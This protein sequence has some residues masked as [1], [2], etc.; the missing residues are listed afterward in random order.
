MHSTT[1]ASH[2]HRKRE[3]ER[4]SFFSIFVPWHAAIIK[5]S[6]FH[7]HF[8]VIYGYT[9]SAAGHRCDA[10]VYL[11]LTDCSECTKCNCVEF[12]D[13]LGD[14]VCWYFLC[15]RNVVRCNECDAWH[16]REKK[17]RLQVDKNRRVKPK[18]T[19]SR[20]FTTAATQ[21]MKRRAQHTIFFLSSF[22]LPPYWA[23]LDSTLSVSFDQLR[24]K[25]VF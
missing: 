4:N 12:S 17:T 9:H 5:I 2:Q 15:V 20:H 21:H 16:T 1:A 23:T 7:F 25:V 13:R 8:I 18:H 22:F 11:D 19:E 6:R 14:M 10:L 3:W 24:G